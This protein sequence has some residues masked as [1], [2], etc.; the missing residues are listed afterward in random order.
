MVMSSAGYDFFSSN[1]QQMAVFRKRENKSERRFRNLATKSTAAIPSVLKTLWKLLQI[2][3]LCILIQS[4]MKMFDN[5]FQNSILIFILIDVYCVQNKLFQLE[6]SL[7]GPTCCMQLLLPFNHNHQFSILNLLILKINLS[8]FSLKK[9][10]EVNGI[11]TSTS[12]I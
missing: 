10:P 11:G 2:F 4:Q 9:N 6:G 1:C 5:D 7:N 12:K 3:R 8:S